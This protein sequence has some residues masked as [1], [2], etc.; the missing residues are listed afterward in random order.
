MDHV[1]GLESLLVIVA[2]GAVDVLD[3]PV[4]R[5]VVAGRSGVEID[6]RVVSGLYDRTKLT[7]QVKNGF[8][9]IK[10]RIHEP[11]ADDHHHWSVVFI[12]ARHINAIGSLYLTK[13]GLFSSCL[14]LLESEPGLL[15]L[16]EH[17]VH[18]GVSGYRCGG[19]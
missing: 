13:I 8:V 5:D 6:D 12:H 11:L 7:Q 19:R 14:K 16:G 9:E 1:E 3:P 18:G 4:M 2:E 10:V 17:E 15:V